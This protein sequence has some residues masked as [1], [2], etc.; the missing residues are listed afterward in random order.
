[1][2]KIFNDK[3]FLFLFIT[4][5]FAIGIVNCLATVIQPLVTPFGLTEVIKDLLL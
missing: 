4:V 1:M 3:N 2:K 5:A